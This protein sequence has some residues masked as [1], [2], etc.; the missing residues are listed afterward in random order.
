MNYANWI[1]PIILILCIGGYYFGKKIQNIWNPKTTKTKIIYWLLIY[2]STCFIF[3]GRNV[4]IGFIIYFIIF[5]LCF[6]FLIIISK[7]IH[8]PK[9]TQ[10][11]KMKKIRDIPIIICCILITIYGA[12]NINHPI[13]K[14][15]D[16]KIEKKMNNPFTIGMISDLHLGINH[17]EEL[18]DQIVE[19]ANSLNANIFVFG[20]DIF[21]EYTTE[22]QKN[23]AIQ[24]FG[25]IKTK[26]GIYYIEG[27]HDLL[28]E[29]TRKKLK[30]QNIQTLED[31]AITIQK[32]INI[33]GR[34][35]HRNNYLKKARKNLEEIVQEI[36]TTYPTIL[37]DHQ[38]LDQKLAKN[39]HIDLQLSGHTHAGQIFPA[40]FF[41]QYGYKKTGNFQ[42]IVSSG[43]G[44]WGYPIRTAG[45]SEMIQVILSN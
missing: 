25:T 13:I 19:H 38:P 26:D 28:N 23:M 41:L 6:D 35:D 20:G 27:N 16:I 11:F 9:M 5:Q 10:I 45:R 8:K 17:Q 7:I 30:D 36:D 40:N 1:I 44:V 29:D 4:L 12:Y 43:Y 22:E 21:D 15:Y 3:L 37:L 39:L 34:K 31:Q 32:Q 18:L 24:K 2:L 42:I 33:I 14:K